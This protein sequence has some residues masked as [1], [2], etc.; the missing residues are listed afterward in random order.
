MFVLHV[1]T[2]NACNMFAPRS[3]AVKKPSGAS[4]KEEV[5]LGTLLSEHRNTLPMYLV[6]SK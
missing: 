4:L 2:F 6:M 1:D 5:Q 3:C